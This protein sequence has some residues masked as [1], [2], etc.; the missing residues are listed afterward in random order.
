MTEEIKPQRVDKYFKSFSFLWKGALGYLAY[1]AVFPVWLPA[2]LHKIRGVKMDKFR[3]V[4]IAPNVLIDTT[5]PQHVTIEDNVYITRGAKIISHTSYTPATQIETGVEFS[6]SDVVIKYGAYIGVNA[7]I[8]PSVQIGRCAIVGAGAVVTK[9][10]P[11][12]AIAVGNPARIVGDVRNLKDKNKT[13]NE[14][15]TQEMLL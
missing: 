11:D 12:Y 3:T 13:A 2:W 1:I 8:L 4:Y 10:V 9:D 15:V 5:F 14:Q 6:V 7:I